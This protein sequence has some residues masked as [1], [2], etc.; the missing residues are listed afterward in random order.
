MKQLTKEQIES[1]LNDVSEVY[2]KHGLYIKTDSCCEVDY[3]DSLDGNEVPLVYV[4][5]DTDKNEYWYR[6]HPIQF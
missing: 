3:L 4:D 2:K 5:F 1:F 6:K